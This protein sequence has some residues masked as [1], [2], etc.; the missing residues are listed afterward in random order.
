MYSVCL[1]DNKASFFSSSQISF[2]PEV[3]PYTAICKNLLSI[4]VCV[5][6]HIPT[7]PGIVI[8]WKLTEGRGDFLVVLYNLYCLISRRGLLGMAI[9]V[10]KKAKFL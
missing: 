6:F 8:F 7:V 10:W 3:T 9:H 5:P 2:E 4:L 1:T